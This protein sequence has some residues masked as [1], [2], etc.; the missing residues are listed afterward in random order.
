MT[1][2]SP[3]PRVPPSHVPTLTEVIELGPDEGAGLSLEEGPS[4]PGSW[5]TSE[6]AALPE[7]A[8]PSV[9]PTPAAPAGGP[10]AAW[11]ATAS[12]QPEPPAPPAPPAPLAE[13]PVAASPVPAAAEPAAPAPA[14]P[15]E[16][17]ARPSLASSPAHPAAAADP[18]PAEPSTPWRVDP[19]LPAFLL[20]R[21]AGAPAFGHTLG[22]TADEPVLAPV[23][24]A[25]APSAAAG[26][27]TAGPLPVAGP[28][29]AP[30]AIAGLPVLSEAVDPPSMPL[31]STLAD[32]PPAPP[33]AVPAEAIAPPASTSPASLATPN[34]TD[35]WREE[36]L[37]QQVLADVQRQADAMLEFRLRE[38]LAPVLA[39]I[40]DELV[41]GARHELA[42]TLRDIVA[43][44]VAQELAR[45]RSR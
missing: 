27:A 38:A 44:A 1:P 18:A 6:P 28:H 20:A 4:E 21:T 8:P 17:P 11:P 31:A 30:V 13:G 10:P 39:R 42:T 41:R 12:P 7:A 36:Q 26:G 14:L 2:P 22:T 34:A 37:V 15:V 23:W 24:A 40:S 25:T 43:R 5:H 32:A 35:A 33:P 19:D 29:G 16:P 9:A 3:G 45:Q